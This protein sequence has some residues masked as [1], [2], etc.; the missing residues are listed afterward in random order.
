MSLA[1]LSAGEGYEYYTR[2]IATHDANERGTI[3]ID[4]YYSEKGE[5]PGVWLGA[6][7][8]ALGIDE[9]EQ[10]T[11]AQMRALL[12][13]GLHPNADQIIDAEMT[14]QLEL[15]AKFKDAY[16]HAY[17]Q[18]QLGRPYSQFSARQ[19]SYRQE[20]A[21]AI[22]EWNRVA[23]LPRQTAVEAATRQRIRTEV[24]QRMFLDDVGREPLNA[25]E[26]SGWIAR[27]SR[28]SKTAVAG[29]DLTFS[30]VKSVS[31]LWALAPRE[32]AERIEAAHHAAI[33]DVIAFIENE[34]LYTRVGR[35]SVRQVEVA[36]LIATAFDH[37]DSRAGDPDL[38]THLVVSNN[39]LREDGRWGAIDGRMIYRYTVACS[40]MYNT[41]LEAHLETELGLVFA[42]RGEVAGKRPIREVV[43]VDERLVHEWSKRGNAIRRTTDRLAAQFQE[44]HGREPTALELVDLSQQ[45]TLSTRASKH[46][47][48]SHA[49][50]RATWRADAVAV[51]GSQTAVEAMV[52][53]A[54]SQQIPD[55][56]AVTD[57]W[58]T[59]TA[60]HAVE[61]VSQTRATWQHHHI[62]A[63]IERR[64]RGRVAPAEWARVVTA[65][66]E[67]ALAEP[68]SLPRALHDAAPKVGELS[69][70]DGTSVYTTARSTHYTSPQILAAEARLVEAGLRHDGHRISRTAVDTAL[71]EYAANNNGLTLNA[72]QAAMV[73]TFATSGAR[74]QVGLAP[75][76]TGK[77]T[78][79]RVLADAW[80]SAGGTVIGL[81]PT[82]SAAVT[83]A[84][85]TDVECSTVD[86]LV[87]LA[88][89]LEAGELDEAP[90]WLDMVGPR[91]L[92]IL[93]E[94]A[95]ASTLTLDRAVAWLLERGA[96]VRA[97]G[98]E[99]Q[100]SSVAAGGVIRDIV[101]HAG[102]ANL[103]TVMRF[104]DAG[105][106]AASLAVR[107]GD[108][109]GLAYYTDHDRIRIGALDAVVEQ[110]YLAWA[111]DIE[112]GRDAAL[113]AP[114]RELVTDLNARARLDRLT[115]T[116]APVET[117]VRLADGLSASTGDIIC[118][119]L[120]NRRLRISRTD[121]VRNGAR[122][123]V[124]Q[125]H[126][127]G[128]IT[129]AHLGSGRRVTLPADYVAEHTQ[130]G[131]ATTIDSAQ[132]LTSDTCHTVLTGRE[133]R[134]QLYVGLT[135]GRESNRLW[136]STS[137]GTEPN[138][139]EYES[140]RPPT[141]LDLLTRVLAREGVQVSAATADAQ[142]RDP[143]RRLAA[144][145]DSYLDALGVA[146]ETCY[147]A[148]QLTALDTAAE[149]LL[150][151]LTA[152]AAY[153]VLRQH[154]VTLALDGQ[155]PVQ[156]LHAAISA[157]ELDTAADPAA[158]LD[159][160]IDPTGQ[161]SLLNP[162]T[163]TPPTP[164]TARPPLGWLPRVPD[165]LREA[166]E[167][168]PHLTARVTQIR[169]LADQVRGLARTWLEA[170]PDRVPLWAQP[171]LDHP[172]TMAA[173]AI[174]R[175]GHD[176]PD[177]DR[178]YT[179]PTVLPHLERDI[180]HDLDED[181]A[182]K[183]GSADTDVRR[184]AALADQLDVHGL[185]ADPVW[186]LLA[187]D[188]SRAEDHGNPL[189][190]AALAAAA[191]RPLPEDQP[192]A[193][194]RWRLAE[195]L[196]QIPPA[197]PDPDRGLAWLIEHDWLRRMNDADLAR[198]TSR[199]RTRIRNVEGSGVGTRIAALI[200][201]NQ[202]DRVTAAHQRL[203][204]DAAHIRRA[205]D[206]LARIDAEIRAAAEHLRALT[207]EHR[208]LQT[209][210]APRWSR[211]QHDTAL[212]EKRRALQAAREA[213]DQHLLHRDRVLAEARQ[214]G[215][216]PQRWTQILAAADDTETR[217]AELAA[218]Q[219]ADHA[220]DA[221]HT[222]DVHEV[223]QLQGQL[224]AAVTEHRRR[225]Q[226]DELDRAHE[227]DLRQA[228]TTNDAIHA[229]GI[230]DSAPTQSEPAPAQKR[231]QPPP[232]PNYDRDHGNDMGL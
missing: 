72:G 69:R 222:R 188:L 6:G 26:L 177:T 94:A 183:I 212:E 189:A 28:P 5:S 139:Y 200:D 84:E 33:C 101:A 27:A 88:R 96:S 126:E 21:K 130:L 114:T 86:L 2:V 95:K 20:C 11:E 178:R 158:V 120:N 208:Q 38:H 214:A 197:E 44:D 54:L 133:S 140:V 110:A 89:R 45:A 193:A 224:R 34:V 173:V 87:S 13:E 156:V 90:V 4:A 113:L 217:D 40:E 209:S 53:T 142:A 182:R 226:L 230:L 3:G 58:I 115:H 129:A 204:H 52:N 185:T 85:E 79:M 124:Q 138:L 121:Y 103:T 221:H 172:H 118:T 137:D 228:L 180:Q 154:L 47:A 63:E 179:G 196:E 211:R 83:L 99:R 73:R 56:A 36:G 151:G 116:G 37:R 108:P 184:W 117:E 30:P 112:Q 65:A 148:D 25:R 144:A 17:K 146:A 161:H 186:P 111:A 75:A 76:G 155:D 215:L 122:W 105:E 107:D 50:Q 60:A 131:Y 150:P 14:R 149:T 203:D 91:T 132:G 176:I 97:I 23:G 127:D 152:A 67:T 70:S 32:D 227:N 162:G 141:A 68:I 187:A 9:G 119:R 218:A 207:E 74:L 48:R 41:R 136:L 229:T 192:A 93:D 210:K 157:R 163:N 10:V 51:L 205:Q 7:L 42:D 102:S 164:L 153:P 77:T 181:I 22:A 231:H 195:Q 170:E 160:R 190:D 143:R 98:D 81:A 166:P 82:A 92:V 1:K 147:G 100:L 165:Q 49:E 174:W 168:G 225:N 135:R 125:V 104:R 66:T 128:R 59:A 123:S 169:E 232:A 220:R 39:V 199:L 16:R 64:L 175:A 35:H 8:A 29:F 31:A 61:V 202:L 194:L 201:G 219:R 78:S 24:A 15:G 46:A 216:A 71:V 80:K 18:A 145:V 62:R 223:E 12:G 198:E 171:L 159:W 19:G 43:G 106:R 109:A 167:F 57:D 213:H 134:P 55:R 191:E 206:E